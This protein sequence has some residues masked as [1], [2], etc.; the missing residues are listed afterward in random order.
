MQVI[1]QVSLMGLDSSKGPG[2]GDVPPNG[3][4]DLLRPFSTAENVV[5]Y[6]TSVELPSPNCLIY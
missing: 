6:Q 3:S 5:P 2:P 4:C 1:R